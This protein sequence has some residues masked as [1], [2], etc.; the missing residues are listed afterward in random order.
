MQPTV[1]SSEEFIKIQ[2]QTTC[3]VLNKVLC[4]TVEPISALMIKVS[5][6]Q[7]NNEAAAGLRPC[8]FSCR[9]GQKD[10]TKKGTR[11]TCKSCMTP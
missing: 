2:R 3:N 5:F 8:S 10:T 11:L 1:A 4:Y 7:Y 6:I 9:G